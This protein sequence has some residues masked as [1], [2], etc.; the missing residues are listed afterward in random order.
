[1]RAIVAVD[2][3]GGIA[4][5]GG[6]PWKIKED[7]K[8]FRWVTTNEHVVMGSKTYLT[9]GKPLPK[10]VN[11]VLSRGHRFDD[12][13]V[14]LKGFEPALRWAQERDAIIMGGKEVYDLFAPYITTWIVTKVNEVYDCDMKI[15]MSIINQI[16]V[17]QH[18]MLCHC[19]TVAVHSSS[20][21]NSIEYPHEFNP[22]V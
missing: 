7:M 18:F 3:H 16:P 10:R 6:I 19:C 9:I 8:W 1:M 11:G 4:K 21:F 5:D 14:N 22:G 13:C 15:D 2:R 20:K 12:G 17:V